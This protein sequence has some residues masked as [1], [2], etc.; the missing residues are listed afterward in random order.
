MWWKV[1]ELHENLQNI[2]TFLINMF[3]N[4]SHAILCK[5]CRA[6]KLDGVYNVTPTKV[7]YDIEGDKHAHFF[8]NGVNE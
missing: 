8:K 6:Q 1:L 2:S 3:K 5:T 7:N 4:M